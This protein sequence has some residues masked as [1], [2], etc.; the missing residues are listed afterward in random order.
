MS[1]YF[2]SAALVFQVACG[3]QLFNN[4]VAEFTWVIGEEDNT[5]IH[6]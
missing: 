1:K 2:K 4:Y 3:V 5:S 6:F